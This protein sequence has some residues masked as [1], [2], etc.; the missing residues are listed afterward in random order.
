MIQLNDIEMIRS[1]K[2][3]L[4]LYGEDGGGQQSDLG[5]G[6]RAADGR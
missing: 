2:E 1:G 4:I 3:F 6:E 5:F